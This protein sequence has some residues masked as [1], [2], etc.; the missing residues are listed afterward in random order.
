MRKINEYSHSSKLMDFVIKHNGEV[1]KFNLH[2]ELKINENRIS[3]EILAQPSSY[4][5]LTMLHK[6]FI[7]ELGHAKIEESKAYASSYLKY[8]KEVNPETQRSNSEE[9]AKQKAERSILYLKAQR[10]VVEINY[11]VN[12]IEACVRAFETRGSM[13]QTLSANRRKE[14]L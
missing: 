13:I 12:R 5:F 10:K 7:K 11:T 3:S 8:K 4:G 6:E 2:E 1:F 14:T 9:V